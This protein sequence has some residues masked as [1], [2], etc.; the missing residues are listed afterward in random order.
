MCTERQPISPWQQQLPN[1]IRSGRTGTARDAT[2]G[3]SGN[4]GAGRANNSSHCFT[5][6]TAVPSLP[7]TQQSCAWRREQA[8]SQKPT[9][10]LHH[11]GTRTDAY[12]I[13]FQDPQAPKPYE[14]KLFIL[15][16]EAEDTSDILLAAKS[17]SNIMIKIYREQ[18]RTSQWFALLLWF[19]RDFDLG[20]FLYLQGA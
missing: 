8:A 19:R 4:R 17:T 12:V 1:T 18:Y 14:V 2:E 15:E 6:R 16:E 9:A 11:M 13:V 20:T 7:E 3:G 10:P 5:Q